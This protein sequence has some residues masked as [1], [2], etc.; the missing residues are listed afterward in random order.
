MKALKPARHFRFRVFSLVISAAFLFLLCSP[1]AAQ[2]ST[3][4]QLLSQADEILQQMSEITGLPIKGSLKKQVVSRAEVEQYVMQNM[5][6]ESTPADLH[7]QEALVRVLGLVPR[8][9][10]LEK[11]E[12][13]LYTEQVAGFYDPKRKTM[14]IADWIPQETQ[15]MVLSHELTHALQ[16]QNWDL[17]RFLHATRDD[18]D[19]TSARQAV[20]EGHA[21]AAMMAQM[22]GGLDLGQMPS[23]SPIM[24]MVINQQFAEFPTFSSAPYF[25]RTQAL[26][27]YVEGVGFIQ[28]GLQS[29]GWKGLNA[30][31]EHPPQTTRQIYEPQ[32]YFGH[33]APVT[34]NLPHPPA[35]GD[36]GGL[37]FLRENALGE[38]GFYCVLGQLISEE[39]A[40]VLEPAFLADHYLLYESSGGEDDTLVERVRWS[41]DESS[42]QF[43][44]D[45]H[46]I[47]TH[48][49]PELTTDK[50]SS[51]DE[52][53]GSASGRAVVLLRKG[54]E[55]MW[56]EG[57]PAAQSDA[58]LAWL[59]SL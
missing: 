24:E 26:F 2:Q 54:N 47:L 33:E 53:M 16:D 44:R 31:F 42:R 20:V 29:G 57:V 43:F 50:R 51:A 39:E 40:K 46:T 21:T 18:D 36:A 49:Y 28:A 32:A 14:F 12:V 11:F 6:E 38:L 34:V 7:A 48:K 45:Y 22:L 19:A 8:D 55:C 30:A 23:I 37:R 17:D 9:F 35:L 58:M 5:H 59:R 25:F 13:K 4:Q 3:A 15:T 1:A 27:P 56:A 10:N 41:N 52:F